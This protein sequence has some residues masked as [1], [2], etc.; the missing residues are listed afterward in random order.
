MSHP[1]AQRVIS[2]QML[3]LAA[4]PG[5]GAEIS[6]PKRAPVLLAAAGEREDFHL[7]YVFTI[8]ESS[9]PASWS[10]PSFPVQR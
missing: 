4:A 6:V 1:A 9:L 10:P 2:R 5:G 3:E 7:F 8:A